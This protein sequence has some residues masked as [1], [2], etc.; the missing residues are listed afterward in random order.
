MKKIV[1]F[2]T[3]PIFLALL[4]LVLISLLIWFAGP[5]IKFGEGNAAPLASATVRLGCIMIVLVLWG[6]NNLRIQVRANK[7]N[8]DLVGDL[9]V[10]Q[11]V[12]DPGSNQAADEIRQMN[13]RFTQALSTLKKLRFSG[14]NANKALYEL[15]WY[16]IVG[17]PGSGKTTAL[18]NSGL[19]FP[20]S[21]QYGKAALQGVG[22]TRNCDWWFT[23]E[24]VLIDTAGRYTTQD[25]H[26]VVDSSAWEG[27]LRLLKKNRK[28]RP[29]NGAIVAISLHD[30]LMQ[31]EEERVQHAKLIR[32]RL[33]ELME[34]LEIRF[35]IYLMFTKVD[36]VSGFNEFFEDFNK[37]ERE[38]VW[39]VSLPNAPKLTDSPAFDF[40]KTELTKLI[41]RLY[42]RVLWRVHQER[43]VKRRG[44]IEGFPKQM[45]NLQSIVDS[46]TRQTFVKNRYRF[47]PYLRGVYFSSGTQ[48]GTPIDRLMTSV[49]AN[50][51][52]S[53]EASHSP[54]QQGK[55]YFLQRLFRDVIFPESELVGANVRYERTILWLRR[56]FF[57]G[58]TAVTL[59]LGLVWSGSITQHTL[60][61]SEVDTYVTEFEE[62]NNRVSSW[63]K[64][65]RAV[66]PMLNPLAKASIVYDQEQHPWLSGMGM[67]DARVDDN[68]DS[69]YQHQLKALLLP[70]LVESIEAQ[71]RLGHQ[72]GDLYST[73]RLYMMFNKVENMDRSMVSEWFVERWEK[74]FQGEATR[75]QE[76]EAHLAALMALEFGPSELN[77]ALVGSTRGLLLR[78]PV[79]Q[80]VYSRI[81]TNPEYVQK[82][83][84]RNH[85]GESVSDA[86]IMDE[87]AVK[88][89]AIP[90]LYTID[91]YKSTD[92]S[93]NSPMVAGVENERWVLSDDDTEAVDFVKDDLGEISKSVK[94]HYL[95][96]YSQVWMRYYSSLKIAPFRDIKHAN[97]VLTTF[98]DPV[99]S[100][101]VAILQVG[102]VN[103]RLTPLP[104]ITN[105]DD[106]ENASSRLRYFG[107]ANELANAK[108]PTTKV[109]K[110]FKDLN[111]L[112]RQ[113]KQGGAPVEKILERVQE[114]QVFLQEI[115]ISPSPNQKAFE[116]A[117]TRY[118]SSAVNPITSLREYAK[119][120]P[121]EI[122]TWLT[123]LADQSWKIV[124]QS[125][126]QHVSSEWRSRVYGPYVQALA[127]RYPINARAEDELALFDFS[128]FFKPGGTVD[129]F[130]GEVLQ[131]FVSTRNNWSNREVDGY[132][133]GLSNSAL[134]QVRRALSIKNIFFRENPESPTISLELKPLA[135]DEKVAR[136]SL[137]ISD[138]RFTYNHGPKF[139]KPL[140]WSGADENKRIRVIFEDL[141][142]RQVDK[143]YTGPWAWFR[144][145]DDA[146]VSKTNKSNVYR[147]TFSMPDSSADE[148]FKIVYEGKAKSIHNPFSNNLLAAFRCPETL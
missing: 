38:Q 123:T 130:Y 56:A 13:E 37:E 23:N 146:S 10:N 134:A 63:N 33:D 107:A 70:R 114:M 94:E 116:I 100:P 24:A 59:V 81:K 50:F 51:G 1:G 138:K 74:Q 118:A 89:L 77:K 43:D 103:T 55:T 58:V 29:I 16:I 49:S 28:R 31:S 2:L 19:D 18:V 6:L 61:M 84:L 122:R 26:R 9:Q 113:N 148:D 68:A 101:L 128:E 62:E 47:Q 8:S 136:F 88:A 108:I 78:V 135:L 140:T 54:L 119:L 106:I 99:Y 98:V 52:F 11:K 142:E 105:V 67:Y 22:G 48:D 32:S 3:H 97:D 91:G 132:T 147:L 15:P 53:R 80:R 93:E 127:G 5:L 104:E 110:R 12:E 131:P 65:I 133:L 44:L 82:V 35:P 41:D 20:L 117:K 87:A 139:W 141:N 102:K 125:A 85:L 137:D 73:F 124:M 112:L 60:F 39:G 120:T 64:D 144:L 66:L 57:A 111:D 71:L 129:A 69:A 76:L 42:D 25:S 145:M 143:A 121:P 4:G 109:D 95:A 46:F 7:K 115:A 34:K 79:S 92:F 75:R 40:L 27:F 86:F 36:L 14:G 72:G 30:L 96:D 17:P 83:D 126:K 45:E 21:E 90:M